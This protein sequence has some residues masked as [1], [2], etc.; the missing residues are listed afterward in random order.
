MFKVHAQDEVFTIG[1][2]EYAYL[3]KPSFIASGWMVRDLM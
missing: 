3:E 2:E 1:F